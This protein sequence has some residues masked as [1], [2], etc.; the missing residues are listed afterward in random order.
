MYQDKYFE[1][2]KKI[3]QQVNVELKGKQVPHICP[4]CK[5]TGK[6]ASNMSITGQPVCNNCKGA[7][8][9]LIQY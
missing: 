2:D 3:S 8:H 1:L 6:Q 7:G 4:D 5:G 9:Y